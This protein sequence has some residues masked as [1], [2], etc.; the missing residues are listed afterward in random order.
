MAEECTDSSVATSSSAPNWWDLHGSSTL[1]SCYNSTNPWSQ[2]NPN[3]NSSCEE[4]VSISTSFTNA[5]NHSGLTVESSRR[6][7]EPASS[8]NEL[9]GEPAASDSHLWSHVLLNVGS[10][11]DLHGSQDVGENLLDA[12]SSKSL[13]TGIFEPA[14]DYLKKMDN[15]W[16]FTNSTS[17]SNFDKHFNGFSENFIGSE[18]LTKLSDLV[19]NWSIAPPDP[20]VN[21]QFDPQICNMSLSSPMDIQYSQPDLC[22]MKLTFNESASCGMGASRNSGLLSCYRHDQKVENDHH[23]IGSSPGPLLRRPCQSNGI[24]YQFGLNGSIVGDN[25]KYYYGIPNTTCS[26]PRNFADVIS[27]SSRL[28]KPLVD[29]RESKPCLKPLSLSDCKKQGLQTSSQARNNA[30]GQGISNEG[31]KKRSDQD[32]SE[33]Q[34]VMKKPKQE[35]STVSSVKMQAP[36]VKLGDRI[37]ALQQI[38]SPFGKT[39][40]ASVL[41]EAIGYIKFLQE[42]VQLLSNP[43]MKTNK[44]PWGGLDRKDKGDLKLDLKSRGLCLV[45]ISCTPQVYRENTGSDYWPTTYRGC[46]YR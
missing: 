37:T 8:T 23:E 39:D 21:H 28:C 42:Q 1:S 27:F 14:C 26:N 41:Y 33:A 31:K 17:F 24:G 36:K 18:R 43:Y 9:I 45:P 15:S 25:G 16:E 40:T 2:P 22:H 12:L 11:G 13:S 34:T 35:S 20:E 10:N 29:S 19:S 46:L 4:E 32:T 3:S 30:R 44:D 7:I 38:V 6:L 5:S